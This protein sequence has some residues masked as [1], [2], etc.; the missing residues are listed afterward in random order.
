LPSELHV[1]LAQLDSLLARF[2][3]KPGAGPRERAQEMGAI[4]RGMSSVADRGGQPAQAELRRLIEERKEQLRQVAQE[5]RG[6]AAP[7]QR[8]LE[9]VQRVHDKLGRVHGALEKGVAGAGAVQSGLEK[10][11][12]LARWGANLLGEES[13]LGRALGRASGA[14]EQVLGHVE[15]GIH[16]A[17]RLD[18]GVS[19]A[20]GMIEKIP[21]VREQAEGEAAAHSEVGAKR[22]EAVA[23]P[24]RPP[25]PEG[26]RS[27]RLELAWLKIGSISRQ[28]QKLELD[29]GKGQRRIQELLKAGQ[30]NQ[31]SSELVG[32]GSW[33]AQIDGAIREAKELARGHDGYEKEIAFYEDWHRETRA[34]LHAGIAETQ[35]LGAQ[36][37][38]TG[39]GIAE[40]TH[41]DI[42]E[43]ARAIHAAR[44]KVESFAGALHEPES[45]AH[46]EKVRAEA[47]QAK[48]DLQALQRK[49][50]DDKSASAFLAGGGIQDKLIDDVLRKL[51][52][53]GKEPA[54]P[55]DRKEGGPVADLIDQIL[56]EGDS[57][58][59]VDRG[60]ARL[61]LD[62]HDLQVVDAAA[63]DT[64][65]GSG[66]GAKL[67]SEVFGASIPAEGAV[68]K[69]EGL[70]DHLEG[71]ADRIAGWARSGATVLGKGM[72]S[73][74]TG[75]HRLSQVEGAAA[76]VHGFAGR[77]EG[78]LEKMG[79]QRLAELAGRIG[80]AAGSVESHAGTV[81]GG[82]KTADR[83]M[84]KGKKAASGIEQGAEA[85]SDIFEEAGHGRLGE[86]AS[87]FSASKTGTGIDGRLS[88]ARMPLGSV[89]DEPRRLDVGTISRM[90]WFLG[91]D[92]S[93]VRIHTGPGAAE[94]T[95][96]FNAEAVTVKDHIFFA[97]GRF[98]PSTLEGQKL[99]AHE[100]THVLQKG[101]GNLD[102]RTAETEALRS[103]H[104]YG[105]GPSMETLNLR[106]PEP[107][108]R[109][110][111]DG[112]GM[113]VSSGIHTARRNRSR[114]HEVGAKDTLPDGEEFLE[115]ISSRVYE[116][117]MEELEQAFESR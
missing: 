94:V 103:E 90:E 68:V 15:T 102:V 37:A 70:F 1:R 25:E 106:K 111:G 117:L 39:F 2:Q 33:C 81:H 71:F 86:V 52:G 35:G 34:K 10:A 84:G 18:Q 55:A 26:E 100:L 73:A 80:G 110:A 13:A 59:H 17:E 99:I 49:Y 98:S 108:F 28:V 38:I 7:P 4:L 46:V 3:E 53:E 41:R 74:E 89:F 107:G 66:E 6:G 75:M 91:G 48:A 43:N 87:A 101:R 116:L 67:F 9:Q 23:A 42:F 77:A 92:F 76:K 54:P 61:D 83:W 50:G 51:E 85:A 44:T 104:T 24:P 19:S 57:R 112:E 72:H 21:G 5:A 62:V 109:I 64:W 88:P 82:L 36:V 65:V 40:S 47:R 58:V 105:P 79:L 14:G 11:T 27:A 45:A 8:A 96:R 12:G 114:G 29:S 113:G 78:F 69:Q 16:A 31:A 93:G 60:A 97:P 32:L 63:V 95:R 22:R 115:L 56:G 30:A 20:Q